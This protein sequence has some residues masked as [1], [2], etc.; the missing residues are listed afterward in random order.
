M[1]FFINLLICITFSA[2]FSRGNYEFKTYFITF[3]FWTL[4]SRLI[5]KFQKL[6]FQQWLKTFICREPCLRIFVYAL[7]FILCE[8]KGN[9]LLFFKH[10]FLDY[11][12]QKLGP[13]LKIWDKVPS[14]TSCRRPSSNLNHVH[15][16]LSEISMFKKCK[17]KMHFSNFLVYNFQQN[18]L[19]E[20]LFASLLWLKKR[21][22][23]IVYT[24]RR[25]IRAI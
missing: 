1:I 23:S 6:N 4:I 14:I 15:K 25:Y 10:Y 9:F 21:L 2:F 3:T 20:I 12:K 13:K 17:A 24:D 8:K 22:S 18:Q 16:I 7:V 19:I 11:I 5:L